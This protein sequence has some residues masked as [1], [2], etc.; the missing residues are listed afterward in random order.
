MNWK[1]FRRKL[2]CP[3]RDMS[4]HLPGGQRGTTGNISHNILCPGRDSNRASLEYVSR[5]LQ[6]TS[7]CLAMI[8][9]YFTEPLPTNDKGIFTEPFPSNDS[10][11]HRHTHAHTLTAT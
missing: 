9:G 10:G 1:G 4:L 8:G 6:L 7:R 5:L 11:V 3:N 2:S